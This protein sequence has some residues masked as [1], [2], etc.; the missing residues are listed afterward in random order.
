MRGWS[1]IL[2][3]RNEQRQE[4]ER[5]ERKRDRWQLLRPSWSGKTVEMSQRVYRF[6]IRTLGKNAE[7]DSHVVRSI[8][9]DP[10]NVVVEV[11]LETPVL[12][13]WEAEMIMTPQVSSMYYVRGG[14]Q[15]HF[16][17]RGTLHKMHWRIQEKRAEEFESREARC[18]Y[19]STRHSSINWHFFYIWR[20]SHY[21]HKTDGE[22]HRSTTSKIRIKWNAR[23][24][25]VLVEQAE[26][27]STV[28]PRWTFSSYHYIR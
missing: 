19:V 6:R 3:L 2:M 7:I 4:D 25:L 13:R 28:P 24:I 12:R 9:S 23:S 14:F 16:P 18:S 1:L 21:V 27:E 22:I 5:K 11:I 8:C 17:N 20:N 10:W 26:I 15:M